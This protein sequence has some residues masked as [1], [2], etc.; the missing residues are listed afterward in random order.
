MTVLQ[1]DWMLFSQFCANLGFFSLLI[2]C[3]ESNWL[4]VEVKTNQQNIPLKGQSFTPQTV[5]HGSIPPSPRRNHMV[6]L[7][8]RHWAL[9][10]SALETQHSASPV[11]VGRGHSSWVSLSPAE[12]R[13]C[14]PGG[15][16]TMSSPIRTEHRQVRCPI[17]RRSI[18]PEGPAPESHWSRRL[19]GKSISLMK[20]CFKDWPWAG[21][22]CPCSFHLIQLVPWRAG[23]RTCLN[24]IW[25]IPREQLWLQDLQIPTL[26]IKS[27]LP[28]GHGRP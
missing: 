14:S 25:P 22:M 11:L 27:T 9:G 10:S 8:A 13:R 15:E 3:L 26:V 2:D 17:R 4:G 20:Q 19:C 12:F 28:H 24:P 23:S 1:E 6:G 7:E 16:G 18:L 21:W 5:H